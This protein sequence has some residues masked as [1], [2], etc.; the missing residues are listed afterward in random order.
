VTFVKSAFITLSI[1]IA[2]SSQQSIDEDTLITDDPIT[3]NSKTIDT[4]SAKTPVKDW[5]QLYL[6]YTD[7]A[8]PFH[9]T[10]TL[11]FERRL[12]HHRTFGITGLLSDE[13]NKPGL[14]SVSLYMGINFYSKKAFNGW[15]FA[16]NIGYSRFFEKS[17]NMSLNLHGGYKWE[18]PHS[19]SI[20]FGCAPGISRSFVREKKD[21][22]FGFNFFGGLY[23]GK[24]FGG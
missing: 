3:A 22:W 1:I 24:A 5:E 9:G 2:V 21:P 23:I 4:T 18:L 11:A 16:P 7:L 14:R 12:K 13:I 8:L 10:F 19:F 15:F 6:A 17:Q 20:G